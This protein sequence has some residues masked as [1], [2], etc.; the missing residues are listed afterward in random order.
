MA[1]HITIADIDHNLDG[2]NMSG[3]VAKVIYGYWDDVATWPTEPSGAVTPL[4][5]DAAGVL[6]GDVTM[7]TG[8]RAYSFN[9]TE[10]VGALKIQPVGEIDGGHFEY[11]LSIT[12][13][14]ITK[15]VFGFMNAATDRKL[16]FI[17]E[18][19]NGN[20]Y[21]L[22]NKRRGCNFITGGDGAATGAG[23]GD[24]NQTAL[25]FK[26]RSRKA[27]TYAGDVEDILVTAV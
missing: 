19:E 16:F 12:K 18:D 8:T 24:R 10:D 4:A 15:T 23:G 3:I 27:Y 11:D 2:G 7:K 22:G 1:K 5:L 6:T 20:Y 25:N 17:V 14:K 13:A 9:F 21:L 26:F